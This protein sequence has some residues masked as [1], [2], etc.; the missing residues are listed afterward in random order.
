MTRQ[1]TATEVKAKLLARLD[2][3][4]HGEKIEITRRGKT[5]ARISEA[6]GP[7]RL[8]GMFAGLA[9]QTTTDEELYSTGETWEA[10]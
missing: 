6:R 4:E 10:S 1:M 7:H 5:I 8:K 9:H 3:V 2:D